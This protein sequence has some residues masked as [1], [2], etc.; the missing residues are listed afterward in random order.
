MNKNWN[1]GSPLIRLLWRLSFLLEDL[2]GVHDPVRIGKLLYLLHER[3]RVAVFFFEVLRLAVAYSVL[4]GTG[5]T[6]LEGVGDDFGVNLL[7][8]LKLRLIGVVYREGSV[9]VAVADVAEYG[10]VDVVGFEGLA[11]LA[12]RPGQV[13]DR[14]ADIGGHQFLA[15]V[16]ILYSEGSFVPGFP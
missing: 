3:Q 7:G 8:R 16:E 1:R 4:P 15:G 2:A 10:T 6:A 9:V 14:D 12:K 5:A 13:G 11:C